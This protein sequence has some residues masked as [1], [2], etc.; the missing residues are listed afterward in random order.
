VGWNLSDEG[1]AP[2]RVGFALTAKNLEKSFFRLTEMD[3]TCPKP[4]ENA[5]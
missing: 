1:R 4:G 3:Q 5:G 2:H